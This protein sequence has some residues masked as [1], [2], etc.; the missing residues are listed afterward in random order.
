MYSKVEIQYLCENWILI[1]Y[2]ALFIKESLK[3]ERKIFA[4][5]VAIFNPK[6]D[7]SL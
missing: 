3:T 1:W 6:N 2:L 5:D 7:L 4:N